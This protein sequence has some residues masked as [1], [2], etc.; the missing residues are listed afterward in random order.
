[1]TDEMGEP[2]RGASLLLTV[3]RESSGA[4]TDMSLSASTAR[5]CGTSGDPIPL[6]TPN[7]AV[8]STDAKA[9]FCARLVL[10][11]D[12][13]F[14]HLEVRPLA[15]LDVARADLALDTTNLWG[16]ILVALSGLTAVGWVVAARWPPR[17]PAS[18]A[19]PPGQLA[20]RLE[21]GVTVLRA[22][23]GA[24]G[25]IGRVVDVHDRV[26]IGGAHIRLERPGFRT[27]DILTA[28]TTGPDGRFELAVD[29]S[30]PGDEIVVESLA[31]CAVRRT[32]PDRGEIE[33]TMVLRRRALLDGLVAWARRRGGRFDARPEPTPAH[34]R[35]VAGE[36]SDVAAWA[37]AVER[38]AFG[39]ETVDRQREMAVN[40]LAPAAP[41]RPDNARRP[42]KEKATPPRGT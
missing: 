10:P 6:S 18:E 28:V 36:E 34:V 13:Y 39:S 40:Q 31:H 3:T 12:R 5:S 15:F 33:I 42:R 4:P 30:R 26:P 16:R 14:A 17:E 38:A 29:G 2:A 32:R 19:R 23:P 35:R 21:S 7:Q 25:I 9:R 22:S 41:S 11:P 20:R 24:P 8:L 37:D 1:V 27:T